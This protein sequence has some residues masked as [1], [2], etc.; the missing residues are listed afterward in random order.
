MNPDVVGTI[1]Q[2]LF[3]WTITAILIWCPVVIAVSC[4][5]AGRYAMPTRRWNVCKT[6]SAVTETL[7]GPLKVERLRRMHF[8]TR[9]RA[10]EDAGRVSKQSTLG[11][12]HRVPEK[13]VS[14]RL[15]KVFGK[16]RMTMLNNF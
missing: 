1:M 5:I 13:V 10:G 2:W 6:A 4:R 15:P 12:L 3:V 7:F 16:I 11:H 14:D 9:H 8:A